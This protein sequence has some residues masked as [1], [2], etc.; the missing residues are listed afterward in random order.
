MIKGSSI[1][2]T[3][4]SPVSSY[5]LNDRGRSFQGLYTTAQ[6]NDFANKTYLLKY[7]HLFRGYAPI[8][9]R[10]STM[11]KHQSFVRRQ[12]QHSHLQPK[13]S[14]T[15]CVPGKA[16]GKSWS[17]FAGIT[18]AC[19]ELMFLLTTHLRGPKNW[20]ARTRAFFFRCNPDNPPPK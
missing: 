10:F 18:L 20:L 15:L 7:G 6:S 4:L 14:D 12:R 1:T 9:T 11:E 2:L 8:G 3:E 16:C 13:P 17:A 5:A 19:H